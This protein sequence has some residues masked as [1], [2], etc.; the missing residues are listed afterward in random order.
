MSLAK[1]ILFGLAALAVVL[2]AA[3]AVFVYTFDANRYRGVILAQLSGS[4]N[5]PVEAAGL[6]DDHGLAVRCPAV[7]E[8]PHAALGHVDHRAHGT[9]EA[10]DGDVLIAF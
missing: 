7:R 5:R 9:V 6:R 3:A 8:G 2:A 4:V 1:K 10:D